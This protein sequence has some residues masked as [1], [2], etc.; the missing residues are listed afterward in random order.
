[1]LQRVTQAWQPSSGLLCGIYLWCFDWLKV[2]GWLAAE[3]LSWAWYVHLKKANWS[4]VLF[5]SFI[6]GITL[7]ICILYFV[8][9][10]SI[11]FNFYVFW[12]CFR[13][14]AII[15]V[16]DFFFFNDSKWTQRMGLQ[17]LLGVVPQTTFH[18]VQESQRPQ[19]T[20]F[21]SNYRQPAAYSNTCCWVVLAHAE[22]CPC[23]TGPQS[24]EHVLQFCPLL[25]EAR[26]GPTAQRCKN[27]CGATWR[28]FWRP[29]PSSKP[30]DWP[31]KAET[32]SSAE[33]KKTISYAL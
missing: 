12:S 27:S 14:L 26:S 18:P 8:L 17:D 21:S 15:L 28:T 10:N 31:F 7:K 11:L 22:D 25:R 23:Q 1:M 4:E 2:L 3:N 29:Q 33:E 20:T 16:S 19:F 24:P 30:T 6:K 32:C 13:M 5:Y 9:I